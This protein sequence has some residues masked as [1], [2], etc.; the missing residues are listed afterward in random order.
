[1]PKILGNDP[2]GP[3]SGGLDDI[4]D[5]KHLILWLLYSYF[6]L[7]GPVSD[8]KKILYLRQAERHSEEALD[9][10]DWASWDS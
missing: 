8:M 5:Y 6:T 1:M 3:L 2:D 9:E 4:S 10:S 7:I